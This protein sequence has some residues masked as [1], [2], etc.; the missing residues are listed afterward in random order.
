MSPLVSIIIPVYNRADLILQ[1]LYSI[2]AQ[3][4]ESYECILVDDGSTD[5]S[6]EIIKKFAEDDSRFILFNRPEH[7]KKGGN[8]CRNF[9]FSKCCG[10][11]INWFDSDDIM[12][13]DFLLQKV[14]AITQN[15]ADIVVCR[16]GFFDT[17]PDDFI[18]DSRLG[19]EPITDNPPLEF[20]AGN[21]WFGT[22]QPMFTKAILDKQFTLFDTTL[23]RN[24]ETE[25]FVRILLD[26]PSIVY[27]NTPLALIRQ[28]FNSIAGQYQSKTESQKLLINFPAYKKMFIN[29]KT[30]DFF[31]HE[32]EHYFKDFFF[33]CLRKMSFSKDEFTALYGF[34]IRHN[35]FPGK[36][37]ATR[38]FVSR[39]G[40]EILRNNFSKK[41]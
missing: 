37:F 27:I 38:L 22:P 31:T 16:L 6:K 33:Q 18:L 11:Y 28:H 36:L 5:G 35:L 25:F 1:T 8:A 34:G 23:F 26:K 12:T 21:F 41:V 14:D 40:R 4:F 15:N 10:M 17:N 2:K 29:F 13:P 39:I 9:G 32:A 3:T 7:L 19:I 24:Q 30:S 20:F